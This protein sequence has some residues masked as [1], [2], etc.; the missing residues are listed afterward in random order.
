MSHPRPVRIA[1]ASAVGLAL[2]TALASTLACSGSPTTPDRPRP[3]R[4]PEFQCAAEHPCSAGNARDPRLDT[5]YGA[6]DTMP[7]GQPGCQEMQHG[8]GSGLAC[9][10]GYV[11]TGIDPADV[12][13]WPPPQCTPRP[14]AWA[15]DCGGSNHACEAGTCV[16]RACTAS[17]ECDGYCVNGRCQAVP[18]RCFYPPDTPLP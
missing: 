7:C 15:S 9:P 12:V 5:C 14:C 2:V 13:R 17:A 18:G 1:R 11:C 10:D 6:G 3:S 8:C 4:L 16:A